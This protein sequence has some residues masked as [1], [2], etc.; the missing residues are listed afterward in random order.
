M[1][2]SSLP[3]LG[4]HPRKARLLAF[5][6]AMSAAITFAASQPTPP[7]GATTAATGA[8]TKWVDAWAVSFLPTLRNGQPDPVPT[9]SN[10]TFRVMVFSKLAGTQARVKFTNKF[11][12][13]PLNVGA[14]RLALRDGTSGG[15]IKPDTD[16][17]LT[18]DGKPSLTLAP[19]EERWSDPVKLDVPQH[20]DVAISVFLPDEGYKP[21]ANHGTGL[22]PTFLSAPGDHTGA[23]TLP[24]PAAPAGGAARGGGRGRGPGGGGAGAIVLFVS[25][26]QVMAPTKTKV[27]VAFGDSITDGAVSQNDGNASWPDVLS[28]R[29]P[30][31]PDGTPVSVINMGIG[32]NRLVSSDNAGP[33]GVKRFADDVLARPN[34]T[35]LIVLEGVND[36][37]YEHVKPEQLIAAYQDVIARAHAKGIKVYGS[38]ILPIK[39]SQTKDTPENEATR[40]AVNKWIRESKAFDAVIDFEKAVQDPQD[41][42]SIRANLTTDYVHPNTA[43]YKLMAEAI[44]LK[45]F[46]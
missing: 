2:N 46:E 12:S 16:R 39:H 35:H 45:L 3:C 41:P 5:A 27:I 44:D 28:K 38:P 40:Q 23:A 17:A 33:A 14:A 29:L 7:A 30:K 1:L 34:V 15:A 4:F 31:L 18:F 21:E 10:Q 22:K 42:L 20:A 37:S 19:G 32:S 43:G 24:T 13:K 9:F 26:L 6:A 8:A 36:I 25:D 11:Q